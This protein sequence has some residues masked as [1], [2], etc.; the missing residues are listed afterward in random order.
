MSYS[1]SP[2]ERAGE[3]GNYNCPRQIPLTL[4][5]YQLRSPQ[6]GLPPI[7]GGYPEGRGDYNPPVRK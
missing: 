4:A 1:L 2:R 6:P 3:R 5:I 7:V